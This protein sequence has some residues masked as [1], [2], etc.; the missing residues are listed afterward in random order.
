MAAPLVSVMRPTMLPSAE[1]CADAVNAKTAR[2][3]GREIAATANGLKRWFFIVFSC[4]VRSGQVCNHPRNISDGLLGE[5]CHFLHA[6]DSACDGNAA[7][8]QQHQ[9][10]NSGADGA[11]GG[12]MRIDRFDGK[13]T[14]NVK[15]VENLLAAMCDSFGGMSRGRNVK[16]GRAAVQ[17]LR[18]RG[19]VKQR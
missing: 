15:G 13:V 1:V 12:A 5:K 10:R 14:G 17:N 8:G 16:L 2:I 4:G 9:K 7:R 3:S 18:R 19:G 6:G 11:E